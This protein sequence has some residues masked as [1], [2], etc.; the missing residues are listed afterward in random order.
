MTTYTVATNTY[1]GQVCPMPDTSTGSGVDIAAT[2]NVGAT[3]TMATLAAAMQGNPGFYT[4]ELLKDSDIVVVNLGPEF[5]LLSFYRDYQM[6]RFWAAYSVRSETVSGTQRLRFV[7]KSDSR[8]TTLQDALLSVGYPVAGL[9][10]DSYESGTDIT[11][12]NTAL[13]AARV[14][15]AVWRA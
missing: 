7:S 5:G 11:T 12:L 15:M 10:T 3:P 14:Y 2:A 13:F 4:R 9:L 1:T 8:L 6:S